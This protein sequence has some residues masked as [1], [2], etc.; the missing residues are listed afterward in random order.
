MAEFIINAYCF[1]IGLVASVGMSVF[2]FNFRR[3]YSSDIR[4]I[5]ASAIASG[6]GMMALALFF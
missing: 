5:F 6:I 2:Y 3:I 4:I 1:L